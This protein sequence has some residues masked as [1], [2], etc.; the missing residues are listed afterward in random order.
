VTPV[1]FAILGAGYRAGLFAGIA[2]AAPEALEI[3]GILPHR[4]GTAADLGVPVA[5]DLDALL[6]RR[7]A[8]VL[9]AVSAAAVPDAIR[10]LV[11]RGVPVL[12]ETPPAP[13]RASLDALLADVG[14]ARLV[15]V[16]EQYPRQPMIAAR[17]AAIRSGR[18]GQPTSALVSMTQTYHA[19]A[20]LRTLLDVARGPAEVRARTHTAPLVAPFSRAGWTRDPEARPTLTTTAEIDFGGSLGRYDFTEGQTRNPLR[21][22]RIL[23]RGSRGELDDLRLT[24]LVDETTVVSSALERRQTGQHGDFEL[25]ALDTISLDGDVLYRNPLP[26]A[27]LSDE[28]LAMAAILE[29]TGCWAT[30]DGPEPYPLAEAAHDQ[31]IGLAIAES[32]AS[33]RTVTVAAR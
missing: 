18:I 2:A 28:E 30:D 26:A 17:A 31:R 9:V 29:A 7:P 32:A 3:A 16:A 12:A 13:D 25:P 4:P 21:A 33:G 24:R 23:V 10:E 6:A 15:Q 19:V 22:S 14:G 8:F 1:R 5:D 20:I 27:R 11:G